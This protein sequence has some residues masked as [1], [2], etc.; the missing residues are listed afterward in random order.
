[1]KMSLWLFKGCFFVTVKNKLMYVEIGFISIL[2]FLTPSV[3]PGWFL[4]C[5]A[6]QGVSLKVDSRCRTSQVQKLTMRLCGEG[7]CKRTE[8]LS[9]SPVDVTFKQ[10]TLH[11]E[12]QCGD[13]DSIWFL[14]S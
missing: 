8:D 6:M 12:L 4:T 7:I 13:P 1:M 11:F 9:S 2:C 5:S 3:I 14:E 10:I